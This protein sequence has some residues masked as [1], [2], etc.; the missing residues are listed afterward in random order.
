M[1]ISPTSLCFTAAQ[2]LHLVE[3]LLFDGGYLLQFL[4]GTG[5]MAFSIWHWDGYPILW[6]RLAV[7]VLVG[8]LG[9]GWRHK[10]GMDHSYAGDSQCQCYCQS[11]SWGFRFQWLVLLALCSST[12]CWKGKGWGSGERM[13][14]CSEKLAFVCGLSSLSTVAPL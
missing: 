13:V 9:K 11:G 2:S 14:E 1:L 7:L 4:L 5:D 8:R 3:A 12:T 6:W 10:V